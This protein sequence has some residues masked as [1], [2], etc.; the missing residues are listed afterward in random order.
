[1]N[2]YDRYNYYKEKLS[3]FKFQEYE[4][5][6]WQN[7][8]AIDFWQL[9][10]MDFKFITKIILKILNKD[11]KKPNFYIDENDK[12]VI[13]FISEPERKDY[14]ESFDKIASCI[15]RVSICKI[16]KTNYVNLINFKDIK[17]YVSIYKKLNNIENIIHR[18]YLMERIFYYKNFIEEVKKL[19]LDKYDSL[20]T[21][22]DAKPFDNI[23]TQIYNEQKK[24]TITLQ[25]GQY[26]YKESEK[27]LD[28]VN[29][30]NFISK[31]MLIWGEYT[32][33]E[34]I[35]A[36]IDSNRMI[37][38]GFPK[39]IENRNNNI[40]EIDR[41]IFGILLDGPQHTKS[42]KDMIIMANNIAKKINKK[43]II[44]LHPAIKI[45]EFYKLIDKEYLKYIVDKN[46]SIEEYATKIDFSI[47]HAS[48]VYTE[49]CAMESTVFRYEANGYIYKSITKE[50]DDEFNTIDEFLR[51]YNLF[52]N[53]PEKW[54]IKAKKMSRNYLGDKEKTKGRYSEVIMKLIEYK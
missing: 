49:L 9:E 7:I 30:E 19:N 42:N 39:F 38:C 1:M 4:Y 48:S 45:D 21:Y 16:K 11:I 40:N 18:I 24:I 34:L 23:I 28:V 2:G 15:D 33:K 10:N 17:K 36:G 13:L 5:L 31:Y 35:K 52:K 46:E 14:D 32:K 3:E 25:H 26:Y 53:N 41:N 54:K 27:S 20:I 43:F 44:K 29:Y 22:H 50:I 8:L 47:V 12:K 6:K 51:K 37:I